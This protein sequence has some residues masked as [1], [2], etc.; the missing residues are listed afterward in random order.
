M[1]RSR[2]F[3]FC[4]VDIKLQHTLC[5]AEEVI[6]FHTQDLQLI[7]FALYT[8]YYIIRIDF[9]LV[10]FSLWHLTSMIFYVHINYLVFVLY[11]I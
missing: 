7:L 8:V 1:P 3:P 11:I 10:L 6:V 9:P 5:V 2:C 4:E